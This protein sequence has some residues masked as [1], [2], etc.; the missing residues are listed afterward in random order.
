MVVIVGSPAMTTSVLGIGIGK[1][2][3]SVAGIDDRGAV[4]VR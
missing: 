1:K 4:I 3:G 2:S